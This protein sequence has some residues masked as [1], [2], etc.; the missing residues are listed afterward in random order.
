[1]K[2]RVRMS[3][4]EETM[5]TLGLATDYVASAR[6][7]HHR[8]SVALTREHE[9]LKAMAHRSWAAESSFGSARVQLERVDEVAHLARRAG[10]DAL[11][12]FQALIAAL[13]GADPGPGTVADGADRSDG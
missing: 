2:S 11:Q 12:V 10:S 6:A 4:L 5:H 7:A 9:S 3:A 1:M 8:A 13:A